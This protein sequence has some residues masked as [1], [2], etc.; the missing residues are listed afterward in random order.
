M[1]FGILGLRSAYLQ[2]TCFRWVGVRG[3]DGGGYGARVRL[4]EGGGVQQAG[5]LSTQNLY[6]EIPECI[7]CISKNVLE[8]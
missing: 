5:S 4:G 8:T 7:F 6:L 2:T 3:W 1:P